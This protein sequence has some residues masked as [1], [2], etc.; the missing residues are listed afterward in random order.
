MH[1]HE[2]L[3]AGPLIAHRGASA[4]Y[5]ENTLQALEA[6]H[7][8]GCRWAE[9]DA[10][11]TIDEGVVLM[12]DHSLDRTT[13]A[14]GP[15]AMKTLAS[16]RTLRTRAP[17]TDALTDQCVPTLGEALDLCASLGLGLVLEIKA[18]WGVDDDD[19]ATVAAV[20]PRDPAFPLLVTSFSVRALVAMRRQRPDIPIGLACLRP[21]RRPDALARELG[22][23]AVHCDADCTTGTDIER[24]REVGLGVAV[25]TINTASV[26]RSFLDTGAHG[27][28]TDHPDLL[29]PM[30]ARE[31]KDHPD[32]TRDRHETPLG[33]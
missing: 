17:E 1:V 7:R 31:T 33:R 14:S 8:M 18:T 15:V 32:S 6:A 19:A 21:P 29:D 13:N 10:Q 2:T 16:I 20:L 27:I 11:V 4:R 30:P 23:S 28:I 12:H 5:P 25:A 22:L 3:A 9:V 24:M 26:A